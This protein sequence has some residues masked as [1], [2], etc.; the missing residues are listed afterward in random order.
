ME[1]SIYER[2]PNLAQAKKLNIAAIVATVVVFALVVITHGNHFDINVD[3]SFL[4]P[5]YSG[6]NALAAIALIAAL[7]FIK[8]K[9]VE[10]HRKSIYAAFT[11][12]IL[13]L[14]L[15]VVYHYTA[16]E[17][18]F[19]DINHD[20]IVDATEKAA[21]GGI[22]NIYLIILLTHIVLAALTLPFILFTFIK[23]YT[24][25]IAQHRKMARWVYPLWLYVAITGPIC[26][27]ML[28]PYYP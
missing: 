15:Y 5:F 17:V 7:Y 23:A 24:N 18:R 8:N 2:E 6:L 9:N 26:Y 21:V 20:G 27:L 10:A 19:G 16:S 3:F 11:F 28:M 22:R 14:L 13:F 1:K 25:Q 12:S 4:P